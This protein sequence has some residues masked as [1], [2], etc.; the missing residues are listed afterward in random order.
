MHVFVLLFDVGKETEGI[1]SLEI[2]GKTVV[3]MFEDYDDAI[4]YCGLLE[5]Q[6][7]PLP[8]VE[9]IDVAEIKQ[10]CTDSGYEARLVEKGFI[11]NNEED[12]LL[13]SPPENNMDVSD[14]NEQVDKNVSI[15]DNN[16]KLVDELD[17]IRKRL[18][19]LV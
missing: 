6:D 11:P 16:S 10:F 8:E 19:D 5:A 2:T 4:R 13:I 18:E 17:V 1:H 9:K 7:F 12:R 14:W 15:K 3:L